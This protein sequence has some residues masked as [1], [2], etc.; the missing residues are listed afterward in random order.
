MHRRQ[1]GALANR[2]IHLSLLKENTMTTQQPKP[3]TYDPKK[4][5]KFEPGT[6]AQPAPQAE[7]G[8][9]KK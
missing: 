8:R 1:R 3:A 4:G 5:G 9:H 2:C 7:P 6:K